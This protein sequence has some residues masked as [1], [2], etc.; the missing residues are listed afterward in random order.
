[1]PLCHAIEQMAERQELLAAVMER[2]KILQREVPEE[3]Q[4]QFFREIKELEER[5][6]KEE[7][8]LLGKKHGLERMNK[9]RRHA[10][11]ED[12]R[13]KFAVRGGFT[14]TASRSR[15]SDIE[16]GSPSF[17][18]ICHPQGISIWKI[19]RKT[20]GM[21]KWKRGR[22]KACCKKV[23]LPVRQVDPRIRSGSCMETEGGRVM[24]EVEE[25]LA[26]R[27]EAQLRKEER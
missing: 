17:E 25:Q 2:K 8:D 9:E 27:V 15:A 19:W 7:L 5:L 16:A 10:K 1:M 24:C 3:F 4:K 20:G 11:T 18:K 12:G 23:D 26:V 6:F 22:G 21:P 14:S 13:E